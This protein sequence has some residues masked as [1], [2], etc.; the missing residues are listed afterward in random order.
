MVKLRTWDG[1]VLFIKRR[2]KC[3]NFAEIVAESRK[4]FSKKSISTFV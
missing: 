4:M 1:R 2:R 3:C